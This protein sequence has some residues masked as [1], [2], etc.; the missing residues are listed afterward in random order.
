M[1]KDSMSWERH[2]ISKLLRGF[3]NIKS[4][5]AKKKK[6]NKKGKEKEK[7]VFFLNYWKVDNPE[8]KSLT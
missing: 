3:Y 7:Q 8:K 4:L 5:K 2:F 1:K 6:E